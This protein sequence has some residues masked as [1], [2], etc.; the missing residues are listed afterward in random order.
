MDII[1]VF[2]MTAGMLAYIFGGLAVLG[3]VEEKMGK[4]ASN[5]VGVVWFAPV[6]LVLARFI[7][8]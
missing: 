2:L 6:V 8:L 4:R 5:V 3:A 7:F 1:T